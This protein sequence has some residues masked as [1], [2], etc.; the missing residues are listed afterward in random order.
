[1]GGNRNTNVLILPNGS[2]NRGLEIL[3]TFAK[4]SNR[5][6]KMGSKVAQIGQRK[7]ARDGAYEL[8]PSPPWLAING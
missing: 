1:M 8:N 6:I 7:G 3:F 2:R 5:D 4:L